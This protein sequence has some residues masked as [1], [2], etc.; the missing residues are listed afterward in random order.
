MAKKHKSRTILIKLLSTA[1]T[2]WFYTISRP[3]TSPKLS[4]IKFDPRVRK[5]VLFEETKIK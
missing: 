4:L 1:G 5:R 2:G 3:R